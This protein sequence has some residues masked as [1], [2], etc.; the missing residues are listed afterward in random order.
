MYNG[1][2]REVLMITAGLITLI[3][4]VRRTRTFFYVRSQI[5]SRMPNFEISKVEAAVAD[6]IFERQKRS[7]D[8]V[9][10]YVETLRQL[11]VAKIGDTFQLPLETIS[12]EDTRPMKDAAGNEVKD[13]AGNTV[14]ENYTEE[15]QILK[16]SFDESE[17]ADDPYIT[18]RMAKR[19]FNAAAKVLGFSLNWKEPKGWLIARAN[20]SEV[21]VTTEAPAEA[22]TTPA[23]PEAPTE[24]PTTQTTSVASAPAAAG[25]RVV[26]RG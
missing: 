11:G 25:R 18:V 22:P 4:L 24:A 17:D 23:A 8:N 3:L 10:E 16:G 6:S 15:V 20:K 26:R 13:A 9:E 14:Q 7:A 19:R 12:V 1:R 5:E 21:K 2:M